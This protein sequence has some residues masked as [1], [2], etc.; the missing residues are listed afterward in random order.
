MN[1]KAIKSRRGL[2]TGQIVKSAL[3][4]ALKK[5]HPLWLAQYPNQYVE[6]MKPFLPRGWFNWAI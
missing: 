4:E 3:W 1:E 6:G 2:L 5:F